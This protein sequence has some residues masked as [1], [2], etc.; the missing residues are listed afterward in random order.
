MRPR[1]DL[2][3]SHHQLLLNN[4]ENRL[5]FEIYPEDAPNRMSWYDGVEYCKNLGNG[6]RLPTKEELNLMYIELCKKGLG[7][8]DSDYYWSSSEEGF[9]TAWGQNISHGMQLYGNRYSN[10]C[11]RAVR[12][13]M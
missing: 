5:V 1:T 11:M 6:W 7:G 3:N 13:F 10:I 12:T 9:A 2:K 4:L 8:F